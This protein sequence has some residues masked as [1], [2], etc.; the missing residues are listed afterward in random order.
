MMEDLKTKG[1]AEKKAEAVKYS[2]FQQWCTDQKRIKTNEINAGNDKMEQLKATIQKEAANIRDL[3]ARIE[4]LDE[5]VGRW[6]QDKGA[7]AT[8]RDRESVDFKATVADY[9]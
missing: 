7:A 6:T 3:T 2:A 4:E 5:D 1:I 8:V 9:T